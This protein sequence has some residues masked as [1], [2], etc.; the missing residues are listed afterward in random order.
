MGM[1]NRAPLP[2]RED[3]RLAPGQ[4]LLDEYEAFVRERHAIW[5]K[6]AMGLPAPWTNHPVLRTWRFTNVYRALDTGSQLAIEMQR[7][8]STP[9]D[10]VLRAFV[11]RL[12]N[13]V[14]PW[15]AW[16]A[17]HGRWPVMDDVADGTLGGFLLDYNA[18]HGGLFSSA[19]IISPGPEY[20]G[21][22]RAEWLDDL[23]SDHFLPGT[24]FTLPDALA[25]P[26]TT[27]AQRHAILTTVHR[28][29]PF[30]AM[31][32]LTDI[33]YSTPLQQDEDEFVVAGPGARRGLRALGVQ[34]SKA[35]VTMRQLQ[36]LFRGSLSIDVGGTERSPS[37]M[38][39]QNTLCEFGKYHGAISEAGN[40]YRNH[41]SG[42]PLLAHHTDPIFP[43]HWSNS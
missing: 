23:L 6:R 41:V 18:N 16:Y 36:Q 31:Q 33:G 8:A 14:A 26:R 42:N 37:L 40:R 9:W 24:G 3:M 5:E 25:D 11:Y 34:P 20:R 7:D 17:H 19:Y 29:G 15:R 12:T 30:L 21:R 43:E 2:T 39:V 1:R 32:I 13:Q 38:D 35:E 28:V 27:M 22:T 4:T 10:A